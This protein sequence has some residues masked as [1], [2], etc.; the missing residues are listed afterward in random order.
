MKK[1]LIILAAMSTLSCNSGEKSSNS[2]TAS[3]DISSDTATTLTSVDT[4]VS[5]FINNAMMANAV[6]VEAAQLA[7]E[8]SRDEKVKSFANMMVADHGKAVTG[9]KS[10][11][12]KKRVELPMMVDS[13][14]DWAAPENS[15]AKTA[16]DEEEKRGSQSRPGRDLTGNAA[17]SNQDA[18]AGS[19]TGAAA[20][21]GNARYVSHQEKLNKLRNRTGGDFD[22]EYLKMMAKDHREAVGLFE[23]GANNTD[24]DIK[25]FAEQ[26]LP[27]LKKHQKEADALLNSLQSSPKD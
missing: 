15:A 21:G 5:N 7:L 23:K 14:E 17:N 6:E 12:N 16:S 24:P 8:K 9:L 1:L 20:A 10:L 3:S 26:L 25:A 4:T 27:V 13:D 18:S 2:G 22:L 11:A 19:N